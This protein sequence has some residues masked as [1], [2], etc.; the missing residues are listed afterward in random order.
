MTLKRVVFFFCGCVCMQVCTNS[1]LSGISLQYLMAFTQHQEA[2][3]TE[4]PPPAP[5]SSPSF[6]F[7]VLRMSLQSHTH[8]SQ[9]LLKRFCGLRNFSQLERG[10]LCLTLLQMFLVDCCPPSQSVPRRMPFKCA[11]ERLP[12]AKIA[13][14][15]SALTDGMKSWKSY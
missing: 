14:S 7:L 8:T 4:A 10:S 6:L 2:E 13:E 15:I 9:W 12:T 5:T 1:K 3:S 11:M